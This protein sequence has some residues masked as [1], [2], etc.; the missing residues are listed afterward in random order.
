M[1]LKF[2][3]KIWQ[4]GRQIRGRCGA[5]Q[6]F[7]LL[8]VEIEILAH[9]FFQRESASMRSA[10]DLSLTQLG[11]SVFDVD[12]RGTL[13]WCEMDLEPPMSRQPSTNCQGL[14]R[15]LVVHHLDMGDSQ[16]AGHFN[17]RQ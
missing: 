8:I 12:E 11:R 2:A 5:S 9:G 3:Y 7:G 10:F 14:K 15:A 17:S 13:R 6:A 16:C 1:S 4:G